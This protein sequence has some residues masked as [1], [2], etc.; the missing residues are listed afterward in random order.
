MLMHGM[1]QK[2]HGRMRSNDVWVAISGR[3]ISLA[4][5]RHIN[6]VYHDL[7]ECFEL[8]GYGRGHLMPWRFHPP[9]WQIGASCQH[10]W[11]LPRWLQGG[12]LEIWVRS[13]LPLLSTG[14]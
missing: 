4:G 3:L 14:S 13:E 11:P 12:V 8:L 9:K 2:H 7:L 6:L 5:G 10:C 1:I